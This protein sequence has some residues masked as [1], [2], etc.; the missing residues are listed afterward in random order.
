M[1]DIKKLF[2]MSRTAHWP[3]TATDAASHDCYVM[4]FVHY[5]Y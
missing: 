2:W 3:E 5:E 4:M 1:K